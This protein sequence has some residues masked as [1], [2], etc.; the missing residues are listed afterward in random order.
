VKVRAEGK[1]QRVAEL[2]ASKYG[3]SEL[4]D[5]AFHRDAGIFLEYE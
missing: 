1:L 3:A 4:R 2:Y 5:G